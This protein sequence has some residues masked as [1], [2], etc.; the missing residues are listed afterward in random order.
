MVDEVTQTAV[1]YTAASGRVKPSLGETP[2]KAV[3]VVDESVTGTRTQTGMQTQTDSES[4]ENSATTQTTPTVSNFES[5]LPVASTS[6]ANRAPGQWF[7]I[8]VDDVPVKKGTPVRRLLRK[9][10]NGNKSSPVVEVTKKPVSKPQK[11]QVQVSASPA[12]KPDIKRKS[13]TWTIPATSQPQPSESVKPFE[14]IPATTVG[15]ALPPNGNIMDIAH[16]FLDSDFVKCLDL[17][18][19][20]DEE[21]GEDGRRVVGEDGKEEFVYV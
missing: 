18:V 12:S 5:K 16:T 6:S 9:S 4:K 10:D 2:Q 17:S 14:F 11:R 1:S 7:T 3:V 20:V 8:P 13:Q 21:E 19:L 15:S